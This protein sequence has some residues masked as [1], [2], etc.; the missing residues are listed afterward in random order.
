[1]WQRSL[2]S[3]PN[4]YFPPPFLVTEPHIIQELVFPNLKDKQKPPSVLTGHL[5][6]FCPKTHV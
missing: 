4:I 2:V 1:M 3:Y 5:P 6:K